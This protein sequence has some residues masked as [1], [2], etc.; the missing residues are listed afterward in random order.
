MGLEVRVPGSKPRSRPATSC[1]VCGL[2]GR[3][4]PKQIKLTVTTSRYQVHFDTDLVQYSVCCCASSFKLHHQP[5]ESPYFAVLK[6]LKVLWDNILDNIFTSD[7]HSSFSADSKPVI[8][9]RWPRDDIIEEDLGSL[10]ITLFTWFGI[11][12]EYINCPVGYHQLSGQISGRRTCGYKYITAAWF[13]AGPRRSL[14][15]FPSKSW[16]LHPE[17]YLGWEMVDS[18]IKAFVFSTG[19]PAGVSLAEREPWTVDRM[20][21][22]VCLRGDHNWRSAAEVAI[23]KRQAVFI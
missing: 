19:P 20:C 7:Q 5:R 12:A 16:L 2:C 1:S 11:N 13:I 6:A 9:H 14:C 17:G 18:T 22:C 3:L 23:T 15:Y 10:E 4:P 8:K 21:V